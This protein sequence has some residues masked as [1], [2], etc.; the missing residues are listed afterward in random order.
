ML[1]PE[2]QKAALYKTLWN[3][4]TQAKQRTA[5]A[6]QVLLLLGVGDEQY[7]KEALEAWAHQPVKRLRTKF[8]EGPETPE[9]DLN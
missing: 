2:D 5:S 8:L 7:S 4:R 9:P 3:S 1:S 6:R